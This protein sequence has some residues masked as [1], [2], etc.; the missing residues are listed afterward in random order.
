MSAEPSVCW[1]R[2]AREPT[3]RKRAGHQRARHERTSDRISRERALPGRA[4]TAVRRRPG[5]RP[6]TADTRG[7]I[8]AAARETFS[9]KGFD[10]ATIRGIA[11]R[12]GWTRRWSTTISPARRACSSPPWSCRS[13]PTTS[14]RRFSRGRERRSVSGWPGSS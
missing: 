12:A 13:P 11:R 5:R 4:A 3:V 2:A 1:Q 14:S 9:E 6:G 10:K 8:L 7:Q